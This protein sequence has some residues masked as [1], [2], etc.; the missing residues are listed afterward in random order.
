M[1]EFNI[2]ENK[3][4]IHTK[5]TEVIGLQEVEIIATRLKPILENATTPYTHLAEIKA[6]R[7][8]NLSHISR[9]VQLN[10][11]LKLS[12]IRQTIVVTEDQSL[13]MIAYSLAYVLRT[14]VH[15]FCSLEEARAYI[16]ITT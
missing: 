8:S 12:N 6:K 14:E 15:V 5:I 2:D 1:I 9:L 16:Q 4:F 3:W 7:H 11:S 10:K 13:Q